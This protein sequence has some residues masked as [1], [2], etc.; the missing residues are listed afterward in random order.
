MKKTLI[1]VLALMMALTVLAGCNS[2]NNQPSATT[3]AATETV[4]ATQPATET[5]TTGETAAV[6]TG[7]GMVVSVAKSTSAAD[8][9]AA[10]AEADIVMAAVTLGADGK[11]V[12]VKIDSTQAKVNFDA[13]GVLTTDIA[14]EV[15]TKV[16]LGDEYGMAAV[17]GIGKEWYEQIAALE[18]WMV[19]KTI[20]E[21][22]AMQ[23]DAEG[24]SAE[25]DLVSSVTIH[26]SD[27]I[28]AVDKAVANAQDFGAAVSG[29][30]KTGLGTVVSLAKSTSAA[31]DAE[32]LA[33]TDNVA[34]AVTIDEGGVIV[35]IMI[36]TAQVIINVNAQGVVTTDLAVEQL[37]KVELGDAYGMA[38]VSSIG[39]D[40]YEQI[41][42][43][44]Q[45][46]IGKTLDE[47]LAVEM[48]AEGV[49]T[50]ADL[51]SSVTIHVT[52]Y[53][54]AVQEAVANAG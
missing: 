18:D 39:K 23:M 7:L 12:D 33:Q 34:A 31:A 41:A 11:I 2:N 19:G 53:L 16:E 51:T 27:Y 42:A 46:M 26:V 9:E 21:V 1:I 13:A 20:D 4:S 22:K 37:T 44:G 38:S 17:S 8:G 24:K 49:A 5:A 32:G 43:F 50:E 48:N 10:L 30:T 25:A 15:K 6:K 47:V 28:K 40:W 36:D 52:D 54:K 3:P 29:A 45:W 14:A 35:G